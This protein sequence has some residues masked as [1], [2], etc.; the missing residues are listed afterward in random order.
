LWDRSKRDPARGDDHD[1]HDGKDDPGN[2]GFEDVD[3]QVSDEE[4]LDDHACQCSE[5][6]S[7]PGGPTPEDEHH[8]HRGDSSQGKVEN[9]DSL[10]A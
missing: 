1:R 6:V 10:H 9:R 5:T 4:E 2:I 8:E 7:G 3:Q